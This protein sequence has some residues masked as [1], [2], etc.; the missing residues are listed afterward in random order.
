MPFLSVPSQTQIYPPPQ[1]GFAAHFCPFLL[2][3]DSRDHKRLHL[4][5]MTNY[6][7]LLTR[8]VSYK[9][10]Q[11][12]NVLSHM[13]THICLKSTC[14]MSSCAL[15]FISIFI[16]VRVSKCFALACLCIW[17]VNDV[18]ENNSPTPSLALLLWL[19]MGGMRGVIRAASPQ[20]MKRRK[21]CLSRG[22]SGDER[23]EGAGEYKQ[24]MLL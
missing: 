4:D 2:K 18:I 3:E 21:E 20:V 10:V 24:N 13:H 14:H 17:V 16:W 8:T 1:R 7:V 9:H 23:Y 12:T 6:V 5:K 19:E 22:D 11:S 15:Q